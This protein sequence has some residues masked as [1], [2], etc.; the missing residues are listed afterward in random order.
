MGYKLLVNKYKVYDKYL[1][2]LYKLNYAHDLKYTPKYRY[3]VVLNTNADWF[4]LVNSNEDII[5]LCT[6]NKNKDK[7][8]EICDV[9]VEEKF[10]GHNYSVLLIMNVLYYFGN[11]KYYFGNTKSKFKIS[12]TIENIPAIKSYKKVFGNPV[13]IDNKNVHFVLFL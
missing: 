7:S 11:T 6:V 5:A 2:T 3:K 9:W 12:T 10:R 4:H 1:E 8:Y 13:Q